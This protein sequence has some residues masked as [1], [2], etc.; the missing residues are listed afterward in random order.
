MRLD[1]I[2]LTKAPCV[3]GLSNLN[4]TCPAGQIIQFFNRFD[5]SIESN[6]GTT[7]GTSCLNNVD[8]SGYQCHKN[9]FQ[10]NCVGKAFCY[11][12]DP[13]QTCPKILDPAC[14]SPAKVKGLLIDMN[15]ASAINPACSLTTCNGH[16]I[17]STKDS[18]ARCTCDANWFGSYCSTT[19]TLN[20]LVVHPTDLLGGNN[21]NASSVGVIVGVVFG[22]LAVGA[23]VALGLKYQASKGGNMAYN[24]SYSTKNPVTSAPTNYASPKSVSM[25]SNPTTIKSPVKGPVAAPLP[26]GWTEEIDA[27]NGEKYYFNAALNKSQWERPKF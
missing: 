10:A 24:T 21:N 15:C 17:C 4:A 11:V 22:I 8:K 27:S 2:I 3:A 19:G 16:G 26:R 13:Y 12:K 7:E 14:R 18:F 20:N 23:L 6:V 1:D 9:C 5:Y 25:V